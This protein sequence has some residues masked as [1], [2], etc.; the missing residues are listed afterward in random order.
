MQ[1][2][3]LAVSGLCRRR[4]FVGMRTFNGGVGRASQPRVCSKALSLLAPDAPEITS[5]AW[6][7]ELNRVLI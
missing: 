7:P 5:V 1:G 6:S 4:S 2:M 3:D